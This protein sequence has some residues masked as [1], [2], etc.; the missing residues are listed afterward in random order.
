MF[1]VTLKISHIVVTTALKK[2]YIYIYIY[3]I[4]IYYIYIY[5]YIYILFITFYF[6]WSWCNGFCIFILVMSC[7]EVIYVYI[8]KSVVI[9]SIHNYVFDRKAE[10]D[11]YL[12]Y[13]IE[14]LCVLTLIR[15]WTHWRKVT[16]IE[17]SYWLIGKVY[18]FA[19]CFFIYWNIQKWLIMKSECVI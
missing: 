19:F 3:I 18:Y 13:C 7:G 4:Y 9:V 16:W 2:I 10:V 17:L 15:K 11:I 1:L 8:Q 12:F 6:H 14:K 5:I